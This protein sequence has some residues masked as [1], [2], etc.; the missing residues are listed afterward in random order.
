PVFNSLIN[1]TLQFYVAWEGAIFLLGLNL[2]IVIF[3]GGIPARLLTVLQPVQAL[4]NGLQ[5]AGRGVAM[6]SLVVIQFSLSLMLLIGTFIMNDQMNFIYEKNLG[7]D[8]ERL[9]EISLNNPPSAENAAK[10]VELFKSEASSSTRI[11][12][13]TASMN[14]YQEPWTKLEFEQVEGPSIGLYFN[15]VENDYLETMKLE[16]V[17]GRWFSKDAIAEGSNQI[18]V[19]DALLRFFNWD[20]VAGKQIPGKNFSEA[21]EII[22][23]VKDFNFSSLHNKVEPLILALDERAVVSGVT[24]LTTYRWPPMFNSLTVKISPGELQPA[25]KEIEAVWNKVNPDVP[26][27]GHFVDQTIE[28][29]YANEQRWKSIIDYSSVFAFSIAILGLV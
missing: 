17:S 18:V 16:L 24:G 14:D 12:D 1:S 2:I 7:F 27:T 23:V 8:K 13:V 5:K 21:H 11:M 4:K 9:F 10:L 20:D 15:L 6:N 22:G 19:N 3:A 26:F 28:A 25:L 29:Q